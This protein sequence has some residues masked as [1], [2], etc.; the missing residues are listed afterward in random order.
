M[1]KGMG[2][3]KL[4]DINGNPAILRCVRDV[5]LRVLQPIEYRAS[6]DDW[7]YSAYIDPQGSEDTLAPDWKEQM[8]DDPSTT[9]TYTYPHVA[10]TPITFTQCGDTTVLRLAH[11]VERI[12]MASVSAQP[13]SPP[14]EPDPTDPGI[15]ALPWH[16]CTLPFADKKRLSAVIQKF[17]HIFSTPSNPRLGL[18]KDIEFEIETGDALP[19]REKCRFV[20]KGKQDEMEKEVN[21]MLRAPVCRCAGP[22]E[23]NWASPVVM[24]RK[25]DHTWRFCVDYRGLNKLTKTD[26]YPT[27]KMEELINRMATA[28][29][30][31]SIDL[32][33][34]FW[35]IAVRECDI[36]KT[37][38][39]TP[40]GVFV[41]TRMPFG[42]KN[43][44][45]TFQRAMDRILSGYQWKRAPTYVDNVGIW[46]PRDEDH[47][48]IIEEVLQAFS[49]AGAT[50]RS[51][52]C[53]FGCTKISYLGLIVSTDGI[54]LTEE[55]IEAIHRFPRPT[56]VKEI[57]RY[58][59]MA[60]WCRKFIKG[61]SLLAAPL[62]DLVRKDAPFVWTDEHERSFQGIKDAMTN[63]GCMKLYEYGKP[64][65]VRTD[66]CRQGLVLP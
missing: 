46:S 37:A 40:F 19:Y 28:H 52:K 34:G 51:D 62:Y 63:L 56:T 23:S 31:S 6:V 17:R 3:L 64:L 44:L 32:N 54:H 9:Q 10:G 65:Y 14:S 53:E 21:K 5:G 49:D 18:I 61:F 57:Q 11:H 38:F 33:S 22:G 7:F 4:Y 36:H 27:P 66:A 48:S 1:S 43:A 29:Y 30:K 25:P 55:R 59:G 60:G 42:A 35:Q 26:L 20:N 45:A 39:I 2:K 47:V 41:M 12:G 15:E 50:L 16:L 13:P 8:D 58:L 24:V